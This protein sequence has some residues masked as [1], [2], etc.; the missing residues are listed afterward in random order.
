M[1]SYNE[2]L[3]GVW[4]PD[5]A[6]L[7]PHQIKSHETSQ[8]YPGDAP[9]L[10]LLAASPSGSGQFSDLNFRTPTLAPGRTPS[11]FF[12]LVNLGNTPTF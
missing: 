6:G 2:C 9:G 10:K 5:P 11:W 8:S 12:S 1:N 7:G 3:L 4:G